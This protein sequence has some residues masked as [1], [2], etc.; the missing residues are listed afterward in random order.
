MASIK[1]WIKFHADAT[2]NEKNTLVTLAPGSVFS[3][4]NSR[5]GTITTASRR[6]LPP[7]EG[8]LLDVEIADLTA[9]HWDKDLKLPGVI[10]G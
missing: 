10:T 3:V 1:V 7:N 2:E 6:T 5:L 4:G 9:F 8:I